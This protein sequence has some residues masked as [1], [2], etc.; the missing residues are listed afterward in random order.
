MLVSKK[1]IL[2]A[3][4]Q[5]CLEA[6]YFAKKDILCVK[7]IIFIAESYSIPVN[8]SLIDLALSGDMEALNLMMKWGYGSS[9]QFIGGNPLQNTQFF[10]R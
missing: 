6:L 10:E 8:K 9:K 7:K 4:S 5:G 2:V 3:H 1:S